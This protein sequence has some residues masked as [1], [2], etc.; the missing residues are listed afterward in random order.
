MDSLFA[1]FGDTFHGL[2]IKLTSGMD[3]FTYKGKQIGIG[4]LLINYIGTNPGCTM[5]DITNFLKVIP[6]TSTRRIQ[7]LV[8]MGFVA[9]SMADGDR[10]LIK[11]NLTPEG[12]ELY[13]SYLKRRLEGMHTL[14][15]NFS[16]DEINTFISVLDFFLSFDTTLDE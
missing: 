4:I 15:D 5:T 11:L 7:K 14:M 12:D 8:S 3:V 10:R 2:L 6:S 16:M 13:R 1:K 9:R